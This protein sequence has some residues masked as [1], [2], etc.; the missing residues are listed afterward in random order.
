MNIQEATKSYESWMRS[1]TT[2]IESDLRL[3]HQQMRDDLFMFFRG[4]FYRWS[5]LWPEICP[6]LR[7]APKVLG[8]GDL[9]VNSFGTWRDSEGRLAWGVDDFDD[10][11]PLPYTNDLARLAASVKIVNDLGNL[12]SG[13]KVSCDIILQAY[14][15]ALKDGG[16]PLVLAEHEATLESLGIDAIVPPENFWSKLN[17]LPTVRHGLPGDAKLALEQTLPQ[18]NL[19]YKVVLRRAG[20]GSLGQQRFVAIA[21]WEGGCIA[22]E[23]KATVPSSL[24]W[25]DGHV[26]D[27]NSYYEQ[28]IESAVRAHDPF[29]KVIGRWLIRRLSPD[30]NPLDITLIP[31]VHDEE[32]LLHAMGSEAANVHLGIKRQVKNILK[33]LH[34]KKPEWLR[35]A[36]KLMAK[37]V[38]KDWKQYKKS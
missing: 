19:D 34:R 7:H 5:Q 21:Q 37:A 36:G 3:K 14:R 30:S 15:L 4:T 9:H 2:V 10:S 27:R 8:V 33:D 25:L 13:F 23:A 20:M 12:R 28:V 11:Y 24:R 35:S 26:S 1:C 18:K 16:S 31:K 29:Q 22:R 38:E 6:D 17:A 32:T